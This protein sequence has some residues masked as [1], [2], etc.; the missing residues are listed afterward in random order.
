VSP[1]YTAVMLWV[2]AVLKAVVNPAVHDAAVLPAAVGI[3]EAGLPSV[4]DPFINC[5]VPVGP[6]PLLLVFTVAVSVKLTPDAIFVALDTTAVVVVAFVIVTFSA[7]EV[8]GL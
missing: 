8:L 4:V 7:A 2:P 6:T 3:H 5:T 1:L